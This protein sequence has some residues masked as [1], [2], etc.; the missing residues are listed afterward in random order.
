MSP[1][2]PGA[3]NPQI[4]FTTHTMITPV[5]VPLRPSLPPSLLPFPSNLYVSFPPLVGDAA[6]AASQV[7]SVAREVA[8]AFRM[9]RVWG[10]ST[11]RCGVRSDAQCNIILTT[12]NMNI[13]TPV[14]VPLR[15][16]LP[17]SLPPVLPLQFLRF[18]SSARVGCSWGGFSSAQRGEGGGRDLSGGWGVGELDSAVRGSAWV[19]SAT[20]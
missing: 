13:S 18:V 4:T 2:S 3:N 16:S 11:V 7:C 9:G 6:G 14:Q 1:V 8:G 10:S 19:R 17:P 5:Q 20:L 12:H 15:P